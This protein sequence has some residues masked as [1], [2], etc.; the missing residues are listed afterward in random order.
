LQTLEAGQTISVDILREEK[1][2]VLII[3]L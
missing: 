2:T 3:Q 1:E